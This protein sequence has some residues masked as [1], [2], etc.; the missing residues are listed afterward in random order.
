MR[1]CNAELGQ[2]GSR[3]APLPDKFYGAGC[4][5]TNS[6]RLER[7]GGDHTEF[8]VT[9]LGA[10]A[11][12][13][14]NS[15]A[16]WARYGVDRAAQQILGSP[17]QRIET[18]GSFAC[19]NVAGSA[20]RR[21]MSPP[22]SLPTVAGFQFSRGGTLHGTSVNSYAS[23]TAAPASGSARYWAPTTT[24]P[25]RTIFTWNMAAGTTAAK[26]EPPRAYYI[27]NGVSSSSFASSRRR[28]AC[29]E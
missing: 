17:L 8:T 6:V 16:G 11:C 27:A 18:M 29:A 12:P 24:G 28:T 22:S 25:M 4:S 19:R 14:A 3:F 2:T 9:N 15:F 5:T 13:L 10:V 1:Q 20:P 7:V 21:S 26:V 23:F